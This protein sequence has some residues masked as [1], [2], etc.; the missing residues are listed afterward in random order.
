MMTTLCIPMLQLLDS[1]RC[2]G[3]TAAVLYRSARA[4]AKLERSFRYSALAVIECV[5]R[6][7]DN[8]E[9][10]RCGRGGQNG[11]TL[12]DRK[13]RAA[14]GSHSGVAAAGDFGHRGGARQVARGG[15]GIERRTTEY[16]L[17]RWWLDG[18]ASC[19]P[20][21]GQPHERVRAISPGVDRGG[22]YDQAVRRG[23]MG[24]V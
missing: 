6:F 9:S 17:P 12:S 1:R 23:T 22:A 7:A 13:V 4:A 3:G 5:A 18:A 19:A 16:A 2:P 24:G 14:A 11:S 10:S 8:V 15:E 20:C 21:S